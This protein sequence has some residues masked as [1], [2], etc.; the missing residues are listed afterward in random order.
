M[1][2]TGFGDY[3]KWLLSS[4]VVTSNAPF[5]A[6]EVDFPRKRGWVR[7][8][9]NSAEISVV[10]PTPTT[11]A[12]EYAFGA[13][14]GSFRAEVQPDGS[15]E[16]DFYVGTVILKCKGIAVS[17]Y[18][19]LVVESLGLLDGAN[20]GAKLPLSSIGVTSVPDMID[21]VKKRIGDGGRMKSLYI[22]GHGVPGCQSVGW[23][24]SGVDTAGRYTIELDSDTG[25][26]RTS[27]A[28]LLAQLKGLFVPGAVVTLGGCQVAATT[29][30]QVTDPLWREK[31]LKAADAMV[32]VSGQQLL[33]DVSAALGGVAVQPE[34]DERW[35]GLGSP[36]DTPAIT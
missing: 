10:L 26:L 9:L 8:G 35:P 24:S 7:H 3:G 20:L 21:K 36:S 25:R 16:I 1:P 34:F 4:G 11:F 33:M 19:V 5:G 32:N 6:V 18:G 29:N 15:L 12:A 27:T 13:N 14:R 2:V 28:G 30:I 31:K 17:L 22:Q 23:N